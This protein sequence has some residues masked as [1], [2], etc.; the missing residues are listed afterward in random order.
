M[1]KYRH[2]D[3]ALIGIEKLP[4]VIKIS[5]SKVLMNG[6]GGHDHT[7]DHGEFYPQQ[8]GLVIGYLV[9]NNRTR[10][11]H[12]EHGEKIKGKEL[13]EAKIAEGIYELLRQ[14][15]DTHDGMKPVID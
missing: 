10:L 12:P 6:S 15:E 4:E 14:I 11:Y 8:D 2:G 9:A 3:L 7:F 13:R 1:K 5:K